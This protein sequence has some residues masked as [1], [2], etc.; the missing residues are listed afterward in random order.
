MKKS[1]KPSAK[2]QV[3]ALVRD[4]RIR[5]EQVGH[6]IDFLSE[7]QA[8]AVLKQLAEEGALLSAEGSEPR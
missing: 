7:K 3:L 4:A 1:T 5:A 8:A 2:A 6:A